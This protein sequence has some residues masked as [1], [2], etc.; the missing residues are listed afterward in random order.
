M[1]DKRSW[2]ALPPFGSSSK[3]RRPVLADY[4]DLVVEFKVR[5][6]KARLPVSISYKI[7]P[8]ARMSDR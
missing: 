4:P 1:G 3:I 8:S 2:H 7:V 6:F 5:V